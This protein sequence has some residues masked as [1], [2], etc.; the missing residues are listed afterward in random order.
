MSKIS[1]SFDLHHRPAS[2][3][4]NDEA[5][6]DHSNESADALIGDLEIIPASNHT[7]TE[8]W[9]QG[10]LAKENNSSDSDSCTS[11]SISVVYGDESEEFSD[12][13]LN[14]DLKQ[15]TM[16]IIMPSSDEISN[17]IFELKNKKDRFY[18]AAD[19]AQLQ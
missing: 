2:P 18:V 8:E 7:S 16:E 12:A 19:L 17:D 6:S 9:K 5:G 1:L 13:E 14:E 4:K 11:E 15:A 10:N 3:V